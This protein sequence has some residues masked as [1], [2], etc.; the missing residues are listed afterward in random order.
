VCLYEVLPILFLSKG[1]KGVKITEIE[2]RKLNRTHS[3]SLIV[4]R[5]NILDNI[6]EIIYYV[7]RNKIFRVKGV[8]MK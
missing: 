7:N 4:N 2:H 6:L 1:F 3:K 5:N 8:D